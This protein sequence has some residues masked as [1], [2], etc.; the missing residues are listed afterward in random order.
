MD[1]GV[2]HTRSVPQAPDPVQPAVFAQPLIVVGGITVGEDDGE[3][4]ADGDGVHELG[5]LKPVA[6]Q[7][8][9]EIGAVDATGQ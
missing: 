5:A 7:H 8:G 6:V 3:A 9:Q 4:P 2:D 1:C